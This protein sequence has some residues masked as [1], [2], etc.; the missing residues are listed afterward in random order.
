M[1]W[2]FSYVDMHQSVFYV[3]TDHVSIGL[4]TIIF[5]FIGIKKS[6]FLKYMFFWGVE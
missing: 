6:T 2:T 5:F 1:Y 3:A 4:D